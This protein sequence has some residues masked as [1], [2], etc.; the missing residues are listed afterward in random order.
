MNKNN[1]SPIDPERDPESAGLPEQLA[2]VERQLKKARPCPVELDVHVVEQAAFPEPRRQASNGV[3]RHRRYRP[4][5]YLAASWVCGVA[6]GALAVFLVR[7]TDTEKKTPSVVT[8][9]HEES[10]EPSEKK[11]ILAKFPVANAGEKTE[12]SDWNAKEAAILALTLSNGG[13]G[14][15][16]GGVEMRAGMYLFPGPGESLERMAS[17]QQSSNARDDEPTARER[18]QIP[19]QGPAPKSETTREQLMREMLGQAVDVIL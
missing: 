19:A 6:V 4:A 1:A 16:Q 5:G 2:K 17:I 8:T 13:L 7:G 12:P 9:S 15:E 18:F 14:C 11:A 10:P 3:S